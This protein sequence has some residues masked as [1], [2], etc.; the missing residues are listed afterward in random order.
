MG[1]AVEGSA[2]IRDRNEEGADADADGGGILGGLGLVVGLLFG[3][4]LGW[5]CDGGW[6]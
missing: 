1:V 3:V 2:P 4:G 6:A 5:C